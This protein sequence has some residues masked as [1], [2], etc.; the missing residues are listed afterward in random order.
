[1]ARASAETAA[2]EKIDEPFDNAEQAAKD[3]MENAATIASDSAYE[4][5]DG[6]VEGVEATAR[7]AAKQAR[8]G[9]ADA[10]D[11]FDSVWADEPSGTE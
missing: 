4:A 8:F 11:E 2:D 1:M 9:T 3:R 7:R 6:G 10:S 5:I